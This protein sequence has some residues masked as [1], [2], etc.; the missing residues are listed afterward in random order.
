MGSK[1]TEVKGQVGDTHVE[2]M[3]PAPDRGR[4]HR[5]WVKGDNLGGVTGTDTAPL[6]GGWQS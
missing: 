3:E 5:T 2:D 1:G 4:E 6:Q